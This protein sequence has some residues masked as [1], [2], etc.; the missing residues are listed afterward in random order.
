MSARNEQQQIG[1]GHAIGQSRRERMRL[2]M[3][4]RNEGQAARRCDG[5]GGHAA[6]MDTPDQARPC[7]CRD[8]VDGVQGH[9]RIVERASDD[10]IQMIEMR[11]RGDLGNNPAERPVVIELAEDDIGEN[12]PAAR[13]GITDNRGGC[14]VTARFNSQNN[15]GSD[16]AQFGR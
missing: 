13:V 8:A 16:I 15:H 4:D 9:I 2:E 3:I 1:K 5:L 14:L 12:R 10:R 11:A 6:D 7:R